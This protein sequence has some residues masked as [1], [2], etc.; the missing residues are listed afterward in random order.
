MVFGKFEG[1]KPDKG[2]RGGVLVLTLAGNAFCFAGLMEAFSSRE[3]G[4][5]VIH[6]FDWSARGIGFAVGVLIC[7]ALAWIAGGYE[8]KEPRAGARALLSVLPLVL[9][10]MLFYI[11]GL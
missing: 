8:E 10:V 9:L 7:S 5:T 4:E 6:A 11:R 1:L 3:G 2:K